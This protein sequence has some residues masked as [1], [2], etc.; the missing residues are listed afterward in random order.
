MLVRMRQTL[1]ARLPLG[2][3]DG[4]ELK[5]FVSELEG[6]GMMRFEAMR[7]ASIVLK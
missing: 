3:I 2:D 6:E 1:P 7:Y 5:K 4:E